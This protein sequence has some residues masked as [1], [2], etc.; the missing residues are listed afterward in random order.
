MLNLLRKP[1][2]IDEVA[3]ARAIERAERA[4][5]L[6]RD[7]AFTDAVQKVE[8]FYIE[9]WRK[10]DPLDVEAR[11]RAWIATKL[12]EDIRASII[13]TVREGVVAQKQLEKSLRS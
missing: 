8:G 13:A 3:I 6:A 12:L 1:K 10:S 9:A 5:A 7:D 2:E 11:E 4:E